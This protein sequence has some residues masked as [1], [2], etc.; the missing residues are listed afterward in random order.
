MAPKRRKTQTGGGETS[1]PP[2]QKETGAGNEIQVRIDPDLLD[3]SICFHPL[4][5]PVKQLKKEGLID[6][7]VTY[8][9]PEEQHIRLLLL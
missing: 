4:C 3:C 7:S 8:Y 1:N 9:I 5:S 6:F 2:T